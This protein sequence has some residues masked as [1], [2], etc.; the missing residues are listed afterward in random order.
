[1]GRGRRELNKEGTEEIR[2]EEEEEGEKGVEE[3][4]EEKGGGGGEGGGGGGGGG[5]SPG[6]VQS[7]PSLMPNHK[8]RL[9]AREATASRTATMMKNATTRSLVLHRH[10]TYKSLGSR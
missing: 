5:G 6:Q 4:G 3:E 1:M 9:R 10:V 8:R 2:E 7:E